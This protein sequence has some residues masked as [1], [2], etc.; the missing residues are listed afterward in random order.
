[1]K[2]N[3][4]ATKTSMISG[5]QAKSVIQ[6]FGLWVLEV[7]IRAYGRFRTSRIDRDQATR[8]TYTTFHLSF[9]PPGRGLSTTASE[10]TR[11]ERAITHP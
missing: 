10:K 2:A 4:A 3:A 6:D 1:T 7:S 5:L 8:Y 9:V 11:G